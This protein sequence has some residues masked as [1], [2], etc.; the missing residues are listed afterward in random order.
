SFSD[1]LALVVSIVAGTGTSR[2]KKF[3]QRFEEKW[4]TNPDYEKL[5]QESWRQPVSVGSP[6][7]QLCQKISRCR[8]ALID[9]SREVFEVNS[10]QVNHK[11]EALEAL[12]T[13]NH[14][15][16]HNHQI[17]ILRDEVNMLLHQD[18][19]HWRQRSR[20]VWLATGD[21]NTRYFHQKAK[22]CRG[23]NMVKGLLDSN[24]V[25]CEEETR[26]GAM[27]VQYFEDIFSASTVSEV[28]NTVRCIPSVVT[29]AM[30]RQLLS[31]FTALEIQQATFQMHPSK[32]PSPD[33]MSSFFFQNILAAREL[34]RKGLRWQIG[35]GQQA[36][37]WE[38]GWGPTT[39]HQCSNPMEVQWVADLID[40][41]SGSWDVSILR[42]V[43]DED[44]V[45]RVQQVV[46]TDCRK[47]D[48]PIWKHDP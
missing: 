43:F 7:F 35:N 11:L 9:W 38:D 2:R 39:L 28:E 12:H 42:E 20:E 36:H 3:V 34:L 19:L 10:L 23:K 15:G 16:R 21:K 25:W 33:D 24:G 41:E 22:Q 47:R 46:L 32:A 45:Q 26:V 37:V 40:A 5:I 4:A 29:A 48:Y 44:S 17:K 1:H 30:N 27:V 31:Q 18:E 8:M 14:G 13:D 6:M